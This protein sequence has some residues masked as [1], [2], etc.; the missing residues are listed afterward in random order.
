MHGIM[1]VALLLIAKYAM[2]RTGEHFPHPSL[3]P[4]Y[5]ASLEAPDV[6][7][8]VRLSSTARPCHKVS[9]VLRPK[10]PRTE[11]L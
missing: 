3:L 9:L 4:P 10:L 7:L 11:L 8:Q 5:R 6:P 1:L 2:L